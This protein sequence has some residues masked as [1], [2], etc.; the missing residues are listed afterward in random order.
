MWTLLCDVAIEECLIM[1]LEL[2]FCCGICAWGFVFFS[3]YGNL[4]M[5]EV[6]ISK[7]IPCHRSTY[8][9]RCWVR[10]P[11]SMVMSGIARPFH[12]TPTMPT[13]MSKT[14]KEFTQEKSLK[15]GI[16]YSFSF[17]PRFFFFPKVFSFVS[18]LFL[19]H[20]SFPTLWL[21]FCL[22]SL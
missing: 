4:M 6:N 13:T 5:E 11:K 10:E 17:F 18:L 14:S 19:F 20:V 3:S 9:Q 22:H 8:Y 15:N 21:W 1:F 2:F 12:I 16:V 7:G